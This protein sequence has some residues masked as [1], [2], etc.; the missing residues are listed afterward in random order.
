[1]PKRSGLDHYALYFN[2]EGEVNKK[3]NKGRLGKPTSAETLEFLE[4]S[5]NHFKDKYGM[6]VKLILMSQEMKDMVDER[7]R[8]K[9]FL[10]GINLVVPEKE[11]LGLRLIKLSEGK[12]E[13]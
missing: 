9:S 13:L 2:D 5:I 11:N 12:K 10:K 4:R 7:T 3:R 8:G 1:M 6:K